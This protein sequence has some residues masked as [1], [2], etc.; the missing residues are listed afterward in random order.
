MNK[1]V[2]AVAAS[3]LTAAYHMLE[4]GVEYRDLGPL[5][6]ERDKQAQVTRLIRRLKGL[7]VEVSVSPAA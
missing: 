3:M 5:H 6:F 7:G 4:H 1:A 2:L